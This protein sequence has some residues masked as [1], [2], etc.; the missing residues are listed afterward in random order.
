MRILAGLAAIAFLVVGYLTLDHAGL[1][2]RVGDTETLKNTVRD[3]GAA[4]PLLIVALMTLAIVMSPIPSAPIALAAGAAYGHWWGT[5]WVAIGSETGALIAF[6]LA[7]FVGG[8][9]L[10]GLLARQSSATFFD[11]FLHS[12]NALMA[13]VFAS[14]LLPFL[15]FDVISYAAGATP[16]KLWRFAVATLAGI[17]PASFLLAHFGDELGSGDLRRVGLTVL[18]LGAITLLPL[19]WKS[20]PHRCR[21]ALGRAVGLR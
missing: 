7:R 12:Q 11:R 4:G 17:L 9:G 15:S 14:R 21:E 10:A 18:A 19:M 20:L 3:L 1:I 8:P 6:G 2:E 5:L 16:L 13:A